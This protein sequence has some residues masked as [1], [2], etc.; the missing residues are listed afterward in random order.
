MISIK[1][2]LNNRTIIKE[3][4]SDIIVND[5]TIV[6]YTANYYSEPPKHNPYPIPFIETQFIGQVECERSYYGDIIGIYIKPLFIYH[7]DEWNKIINYKNPSTKYFLY[8][9]F[10]ICPDSE[11]HFYPIYNLHTVEY[12]ILSEFNNID[13]TIELNPI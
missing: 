11:Y 12:A 3:N 5:G 13:K 10:L 4:A 2:I 6:K 9:H 1:Y 7:N 8:P